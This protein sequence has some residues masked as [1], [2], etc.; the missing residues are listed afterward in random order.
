MT[1][2]PC[3]GPDGIDCPR[4][5]IGCR[6]DCEKW[7][8]W[9]AIHEAEKKREYEDKHNCADAFLYEQPKRVNRARH[10]EYMRERKRR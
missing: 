4:R 7:H 6:A 1:K 8:E 5:Y 9:L 10:R 3:Q 2:P